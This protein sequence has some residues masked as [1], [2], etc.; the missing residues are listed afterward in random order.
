MGPHVGQWSGWIYKQGSRV[1]TWKK[2]YMVLQGRHVTYYDKSVLEP[3]PTEKG[4]LVLVDVTQNFAIANGL[5]LHDNKGKQMKI[6]TDT[7][8]EFQDC[9]ISM[10]RVCRGDAPPSC[11]PQTQPPAMSTSSPSSQRFTLSS[12]CAL[13]VHSY[14]PPSGNPEPVQLARPVSRSTSERIPA[15]AA[16]DVRF[17]PPERALSDRVERI[18]LS[19][20]APPPPRASGPKLVMLSSSQSSN[21]HSQ[22]IR[23]TN[24]VVGRKDVLRGWLYKEGQHVRNWKRRYFVL[25]GDHLAYYGKQGEAA[26]GDGRVVEVALNPQRAF[27]LLVRL[28]SDRILRVA[29]ESEDDMERWQSGLR[30]ALKN[31]EYLERRISSSVRYAGYLHKKGS[32]IKTW[33][34]RWFMLTGL[35][36]LGYCDNEGDTPKGYGKVLDVCANLKRAHCLYIHLDSGR[37]LSVAADS[38]D[39]IDGWFAVLSKVAAAVAQTCPSPVVNTPTSCAHHRGWLQKEGLAIKSWK[40]RY[41]TLHGR[42]LVYYKDMEDGGHAV[43]QGLVDAAAEGTSRPFAIDIHFETGR[44]LRVAAN[45]ERDRAAWLAA[46][47]RDHQTGGGAGPSLLAAPS[48]TGPL[49]GWLEWEGARTFFTLTGSRDVT[50]FANPNGLVLGKGT[51]QDMRVENFQDFVMHLV[52]AN[53]ASIRVKAE[54]TDEL[55][56]WR[57]GMTMAIKGRQA[58][59]HSSA[60]TTTSLTSAAFSRRTSCMMTQE[61]WMLKQGK[62]VKSWKRRYFVV[63]GTDLAYYKDELRGTVLGQGTFVHVKPNPDK[64]WS[65]VIILNTGRL[66]VVA[67]SSEHDEAT[68]L[69]ALQS[70][71]QPPPDSQSL[72]PHISVAAVAAQVAPVARRGDRT[73]DNEGDKVEDIYNT[74]LSSTDSLEYFDDNDFE[75]ELDS[76]MGDNGSMSSSDMDGRAAKGTTGDYDSDGLSSLSSMS[77]FED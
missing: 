39:D 58:G 8:A 41:F 62:Q 53:A 50:W 4:A 36:Q 70:A 19:S 35:N 38:Q 15:R 18:H 44:V 71:L 29:A 6:Y 47:R 43:G 48:A 31:Q 60:G 45:S 27:G 25:T 14:R 23:S 20:D 42:M 73:N 32:N 77:D 17:A 49:E 54:T 66:L 55:A 51:L 46:L 52:F 67:L 13:P 74:H 10:Q 26:K 61:G 33:H 9:F 28:D 64:P 30:A 3:N 7:T 69:H 65:L 21:D 11:S 68:W 24:N 72:E 2:R 76:D 40:R 5:F 16:A 75:D 56:M 34:R 22:R 1:K 12:Q 63:H 57:Q 59:V 37:R